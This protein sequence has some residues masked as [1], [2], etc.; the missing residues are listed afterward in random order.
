[1]PEDLAT[2]MPVD[3]RF[4]VPN[5]KAP[6]FD[7]RVQ[8]TLQ[9]FLGTRGD[10]LD[11]AVTVRDLVGS[12][13]ALLRP[14]YAGGVGRP[15]TPISGPGPAV[16]PPYVADLTPP[17]TPTGFS[18]TTSTTNI[19]VVTDPPIYQQGHGH[20]KTIVYG[21]KYVGTVL[22]VFSDAVVL[23]EFSGDVFAF[24]VDPASQYRLWARWV[25]VDGAESAAP[26][27]GTN[28]IAATAGLLDDQHIAFLTASKIRAGSISV[29]EY[30]QSANY[31]ALNSGWRINGD[32][33]AEFSGVIV[34][35]TVYATTGQIGGNT[36]DSTGMQSPGY[37]T[38]SGWRLDSTG[39]FRAYGSS[40]TRVIDMEATGTSPALKFGAAFEVLGDGTATFAGSLSAASG[41]FAGTL[42]ASAINA[43][44]TINL[45]GQAV[46][47][48]MST[49]IS[50]Q[51]FG[52]G[53]YQDAIALT[54]TAPANT[55]M[56]VT[57]LFAARVGYTSGIR[58]VGY[59]ATKNGN[60]LVD[61]GFISGAFND[62]PSFHFSAPLAAGETA[63][64]GVR[65]WGQDDTVSM[66]QRALLLLGTKR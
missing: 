53:L 43:V 52:N 23:T 41:T 64:F 38:T 37:S 17:P 36:I 33:T 29:G 46:T 31:V 13:L 45:A 7:A 1:M 24:P 39:I 42:T 65:F 30:I 58:Q 19:Q 66:G 5:P 8:E 60:P 3:K 59:V 27:G 11:R 6:N 20:A 28:G 62:F 61:Y 34:R 57:A 4:D 21:A 26:A 63:T 2:I 15:S 9:R 44:D 16:S 25:S 18:A 47:V 22:P 50:G 49:E 35:G 14:G 12:G 48:P 32:G 55:G 40:G 56:F 51:L 10:R 54:L